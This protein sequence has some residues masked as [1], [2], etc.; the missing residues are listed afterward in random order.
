M[1]DAQHTLLTGTGTIGREILLA[2]LLR[3]TRGKVS[4]LMRDRGRRTVAER[5][6]RL[7]ADLSLSPEQIARVEVL[8]GDVAV[9]GFRLDAAT[10]SRLANSLDFIIHTAATTS[11]TADRELC[12]AVNRNGT[13]H[14]LIFAENCF[15][16][17]K[18]QRFVHLS[19]AFIAGG[20][21]HARA[22]ED[23][24]PVAPAHLNHYE[25]SKFEAERIV[26]AAMHAGLPVTIF[27]PSMVVGSTADGSTRDFNVIYPLMRI[28]ASGYI[29][30]FPAEAQARVHLAPIDFV[31][32]SIMRALGDDWTV[33]RTFH[34]TAP[35]PPTIGQL[36]ACD[37]F[38]PAGAHRPQLCPAED[39]SLSKCAARERELLE[40]VAFC[41]PYFN[42]RLT[43]ETTNTARLVELPRTDAAFLSRLGRYAV[44]SGYIRRMAA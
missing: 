42:S 31:V 41:F 39:F 44:E 23:E 4:V 17:G 33:G 43:F 40:S 7:F 34:L 15:S 27:R 20:G 24:L 28:L 32:N 2:L 25:W 3:D 22:R 38:F 26:R 21:S 30:R 6:K 19:T 1:A 12:E 9:S 8:R 13:T 14:A 36:F 35:Q 10:Q 37:A 5:A 29:T 16:H 18:L 11:L